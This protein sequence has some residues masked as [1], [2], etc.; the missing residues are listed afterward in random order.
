MNQG[1][2]SLPKVINKQS[3]FFALLL[4]MLQLNSFSTP[5]F[6]GSQTRQCYHLS[7][8]LE[9]SGTAEGV[10]RI[11]LV[12]GGLSQELKGPG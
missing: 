8:V 2:G 7:M 3:K 9:I 4:L 1:N 12:E 5:V 6:G 10:L 11:T